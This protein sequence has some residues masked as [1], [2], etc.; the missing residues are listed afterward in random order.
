MVCPSASNSR[1]SRPSPRASCGRRFSASSFCRPLLVGV[2]DVGAQEAGEGD[3]PAAGGEHDGLVGHRRAADADRHGRA[4]RVGH[5]RG[6]RALPDQLVEPELVGGQ[7]VRDLAGRAERV[8]GRADRLVR[9][10]RVLHLAR[11]DARLGRDVRV[12]VQLAR[13]RAGRAERRRRQVRRVGT[14]IGDEAV[15]VQPLRDAHDRRATTS[16]TCGRPPAAASGH[17]RRVRT[18][19]VRL[20]L[21]ALHREVAAVEPG[22][23][24]AG[25]RPRPGAGRWTARG[26]WPGRSRGRSRA[27]GRRR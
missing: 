2:L 22:G 14:H 3:R 1:A 13:L 8:A 18:A 6:E 26:R 7:L 4:D 23:Q 17:E 19:A 11:V 15:L 12:A 20:L 21:D 9:L 10:L 24:P 5:L 16:G 27:A 25:A